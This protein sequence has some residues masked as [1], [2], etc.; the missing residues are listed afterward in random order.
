MAS[1]DRDVESS[2]TGPGAAGRPTV[3][4]APVPG[5]AAAAFQP[6]RD[7]YV[8]EGVVGSG[9]MGDVF[10]VT[11]RDLRRQVAMKVLRAPPGGDDE[12]RLSFVAEA[13]ATSQLEHPGVPP[14]HDLGVGADGRVWFTMKLVRGRTLA[15]VVRDLFL[16]RPDVHHARS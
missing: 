5:A 11:D 12:A 14:V 15:E 16:G 7:K 10:L 6:A 3:G 13:Q 2:D 4:G 1:P 8:V 9:G